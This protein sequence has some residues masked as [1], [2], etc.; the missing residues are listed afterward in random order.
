MKLRFL[1]F[2]LFLIGIKSTYSQ[3]NVG[4]GTP[5]PNISAILDLTSNNKGFLA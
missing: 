3:N 2:F 1:L 4:I 5:N